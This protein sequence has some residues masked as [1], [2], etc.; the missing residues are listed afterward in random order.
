MEL[1]KLTIP[2]SAG[3][4]EEERP[5]KAESTSYSIGRERLL[6][7]PATKTRYIPTSF[8][9]LPDEE[10]EK[11]IVVGT[12]ESADKTPRPHLVFFLLYR[13]VGVCDLEKANHRELLRSFV[14]K[15]EE[16][17]CFGQRLSDHRLMQQVTLTFRPLLR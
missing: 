13:F 3:T 17:R 2:N 7:G 14:S 11:Q 8:Y 10:E 9:S 12:R 16:I 4:W 1:L 6:S 5:P 15:M